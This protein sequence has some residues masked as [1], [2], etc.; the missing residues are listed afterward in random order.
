MCIVTGVSR[1]VR[2]LHMRSWISIAACAAPSAAGKT[3]RTSSP[4]VLTTRPSKSTQTRL[5][6]SRQRSIVANASAFHEVRKAWCC[7]KCQRT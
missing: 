4:M 7:R 2:C 5:T 1:G 6:I 3:A